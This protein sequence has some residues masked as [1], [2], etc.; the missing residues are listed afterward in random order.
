M[1]NENKGEMK[2]IENNY[3]YHSDTDTINNNDND[4]H[5]ISKK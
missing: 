4:N 3:T 5:T 2:N 1:K